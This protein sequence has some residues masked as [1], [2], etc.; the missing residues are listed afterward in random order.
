PLIPHDAEER[1]SRALK[2]WNQII[3]DHIR[4]ETGLKLSDGDTRFSIPVRV[5]RGFPLTLGNLI[6]KYHDPVVWQLIIGQ[7]KL[8]GLIEGLVFLLQ[9]WGEVEKWPSLPPV[10]RNGRPV[11]EQCK[12]IACS[13]QQVTIAIEVRRQIT[14]IREDI[15]GTYR[16]PSGLTSWV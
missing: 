8:S 15:L 4:S 5:I 7:P 11:L 12:E 1:V 6:Q 13:L 10:A 2:Q 9:S 14:E 3:R 16:C